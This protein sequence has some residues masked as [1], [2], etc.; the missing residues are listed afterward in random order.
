MLISYFSH[1]S[2]HKKV[3]LLLNIMP[4]NCFQ[5]DG[6]TGLLFLDVTILFCMIDWPLEVT[7]KT[8]LKKM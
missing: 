6:L 3:E 8:K 7:V 2:G 4:V 5:R 1:S